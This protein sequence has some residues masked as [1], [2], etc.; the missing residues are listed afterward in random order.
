MA[1]ED[2]ELYLAKVISIQSRIPME[3]FEGPWPPTHCVVVTF[4]PYNYHF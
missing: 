2:I 1:K 3:S 4:L